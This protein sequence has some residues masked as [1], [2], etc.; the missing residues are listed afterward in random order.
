VA[1]PVPLRQVVAERE[2]VPAAADDDHLVARPQLGLAEEHLAAQE[3]AQA[4]TFLPGPRA[5]W[6]RTP[7]PGAW[8]RGICDGAMAEPALIARAPARARAR[9]RAAPSP[10]DRGRH[11]PRGSAPAGSAA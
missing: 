4:V 2:P 6:L 8:H 10:A 1:D 5:P 9:G 11:T 3:P 7:G